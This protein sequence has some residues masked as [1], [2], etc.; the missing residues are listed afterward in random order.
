M[1]HPQVE[2]A[3][4]NLEKWES[5]WSMEYNGDKCEIFRI[6]RKKHPV[7]FSYKR[8]GI[9]LK[10]TEAAKYLGVTMSKDLS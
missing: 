8:H 7:L 9:E 3:L 1:C 4:F 10:T 2:F 5:D 6:S